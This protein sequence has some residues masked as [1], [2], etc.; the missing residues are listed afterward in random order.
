LKALTPTERILL[1]EE[2]GPRNF[3]EIMIIPEKT[4]PKTCLILSNKYI[5]FNLAMN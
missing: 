4:P 5:F 1:A 3:A 2:R